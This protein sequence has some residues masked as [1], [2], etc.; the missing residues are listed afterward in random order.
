LAKSFHLP[1]KNLIKMAGL[2]E[3]GSSRMREESVHFAACSESRQPLSED[4]QE[5]LQ[6]ILKVIIEDSDAK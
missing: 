6:A 1:P 2:A 4:E 5:A 3:D